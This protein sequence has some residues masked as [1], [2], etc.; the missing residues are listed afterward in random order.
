MTRSFTYLEQ[1]ERGILTEFRETLWQPFCRSVKRYKL[2]Q[3][4]DRI[5][6]C[7]S[8]GKDSM[9]L[10]K[11]IQLL[12]RHTQY[13][14]EARYLI[15]DPGYNPENRAKVESN[16][17]L[18]GIP[19]TLFESDIFEVLDT[20]EK[21][22]CFLCARMR[23]GCLYGKAREMGCNKIALGHHF[24][25]VIET[26]LIGMLYGGQLQAMPPKLKAKNFPGMELIRPLYTVREEDICA[27]RDRNC[28]GFIQCACRL[29]E[30]ASRE[31]HVSKRQEV[32][33]LIKTLHAENPT[34]EW[35]IFGS[36]HNVQLDTMVGWKYRG[37]EISF[38]DDYDGPKGESTDGI[39]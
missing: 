25:D 5:A 4:G 7:I 10:A 39:Q 33:R 24:D 31:E 18:L 23:R 38:L 8:G 35:N 29:T 20:Q 17:K 37:K 1:L 32:K 30:Q 28:L 11:L 2:I 14:F 6:V 27:W 22:P 13:P 21:N 19:Y 34:V 26:T 15:M 9:L 36:F 16:A 3:P 12:H